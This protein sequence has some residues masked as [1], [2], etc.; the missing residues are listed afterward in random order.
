MLRR[1]F[2]HLCQDAVIV[3]YRKSSLMSAALRPR[4]PITMTVLLAIVLASVSAAVGPIQPA[5]A[6]ELVTNDHFGDGTDGWRTNGPQQRLTTVSTATGRA[7]RLSTTT[8]GHAVLNDANNTVADTGPAGQTYILKTRVRT[9]TPE[10]SGAL[11]VREVASAGVI[12]H[13]TSFRLTDRSW[14]M[15]RLEVTT[16]HPGA[17]MDLNVVA[18]DLETSQD[19]VIDLVSVEE[20]GAPAPPSPGP[21]PAPGPDPG[22]PGDCNGQVPDDTLFGSHVS[23]SSLSAQESLAQ[24]DAA[25]GRVPVVR[26]FDPGLPMAWSKPRTDVYD[27]RT[28]V[29]SFRPMPQEVLSGKHDAFFRKWFASAPEDRTIYWSYIHEPE[30]LIDSGRFTAAQYRAA[31]TRLEN[32][33]DEACKPNMFSTLILTGWTAEPASGRDYRTYDA[34]KDVIDVLAWDPYNGATDKD[35]DYYESIE[36]FLAPAVRV[37]VQD[38]RP[39]G[40]AETGSRLVPG[41]P[42]QGRAAWLED[43][44]EYVIAHDGAF[45]T[46]FQST[47]GGNYRLDDPYSRAVWANF[48]AR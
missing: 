24:V 11:R 37:S 16:T 36:D 9:T 6:S 41:D 45:V 10:V 1:L 48:V 14:A 28:M 20:G 27:G 4:L 32:L 43:V 5:R 29:M 39:W 46:Y 33:A 18:W 34:G 2:E 30:P 19:L 42:G 25:F 12:E 3:A 23:T 7:A 40:I 38:G 17:T 35:R 13:E 8:T 22:P 21:G 15:V 31:W 47:R 26:V 44:G